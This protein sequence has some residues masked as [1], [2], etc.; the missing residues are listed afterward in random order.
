MT[1]DQEIER[2]I[3][4]KNLN[5]PRL[6]PADIENAIVKETFTVLPSGKAMI[7]ELTLRNGFT[8]RGESACV[9]KKNFDVEIGRTISRDNAKQKIWELEG[10]LLQEKLARANGTYKE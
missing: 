8:V 1:H 6:C 2:M 3:Q 5:A 7:C 9:S 10:Y 4:E